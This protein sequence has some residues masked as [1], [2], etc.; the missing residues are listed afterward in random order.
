M[1]ADLRNLKVKL[2]AERA[3]PHTNAPAESVVSRIKR[4]KHGV[5]VTLAA[6]ILAAGAVAYSFSLS[7]GRHYQ[8]KNPSPFSHSKT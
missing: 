2:E 8:T 5:L 7:A 3:L 6:A 4:H 1:L